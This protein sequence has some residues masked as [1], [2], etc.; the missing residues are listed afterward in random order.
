MVASKSKKTFPKKR[1]G[2]VKKLVHASDTVAV[3]PLS[4]PDY[5][6]VRLL[7]SHLTPTSV[8]LDQ[9]L[10]LLVV[11]IRFQAPYVSTRPPPLQYK[12]PQPGR[13]GG[14]SSGW[15]TSPVL[16]TVSS[17][18]GNGQASTS[19]I[20]LARICPDGR[21]VNGDFYH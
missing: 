21:E 17:C 14:L 6:A 16:V 8:L 18:F 1:Q 11:L 3:I 7:L 19:K 10:T 4:Y 15:D 12:Q 13:E 5:D 20:S 2:E 9:I